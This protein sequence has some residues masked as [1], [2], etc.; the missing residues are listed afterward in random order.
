MLPM[1]W[2]FDSYSIMMLLGVIVCFLL[3]V[4]Y[5]KKQKYDKNFSI[6]ILICACVSIIIGILSAALAQI[7]FDLLKDKLTN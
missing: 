6:D 2:I 7:I 1:I 5:A 3:F 4:L